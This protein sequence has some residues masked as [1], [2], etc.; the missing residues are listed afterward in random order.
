MTP[1]FFCEAAGH[2]LYWTISVILVGSK[3]GIL[4]KKIL[5]VVGK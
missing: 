4:E 3:L 2:P 5:I 1:V